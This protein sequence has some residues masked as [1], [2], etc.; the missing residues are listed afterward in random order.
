MKLKLSTL[1]FVICSTAAWAQRIEN[2][3]VYQNIGA[4]RYLRI[5]YENDFFAL[6]D[7]YYTQGV[8]LELVAPALK[9]FPTARLLFKPK[10]SHSK[11]GIAVEH[12]GFTP[13]NILEDKVLQ[14]DRPY[15]SSLML[16]TFSIVTDPHTNQRLITQ[17][18]LGV[19]GPWSMGK[20]VQV[21]IHE[22]LN[23]EKVPLGWK[24]QIRNDIILNYQL[25][26]E[27]ALLSKKFLIVTGKGGGRLGS[28]HTRVHTSLTFMAGW[29]DNPFQ[30]AD[31]RG[32][33]VQVYVYTEPQVNF[34]VFDASLQGGLF[35]DNSP[36]TLGRKEISRTVFQQNAGLVIRIASISLEYIQTYIT[37]EFK[38][39][40]SHSWGSVRASF[41]F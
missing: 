24:N 37:R 25:E 39:G 14:N 27:R 11:V 15:S 34:I 28:F 2:T 6:S 19:I 23:P 40:S 1:L 35:N 8:N 17:F 22:N 16:K 4:D 20:E 36:Y 3:A 10:H 32:K 5:N 33:D 30:Y 29:M 12:I 21:G 18:S 7:E 41:T 13:S 26:Y 31:Q 9:K 38:A